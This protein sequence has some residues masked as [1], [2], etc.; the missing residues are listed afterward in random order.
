MLSRGGFPSILSPAM[1]KLSFKKKIKKALIIFRGKNSLSFCEKARGWLHERGVKSLCF[2]QEALQ[3]KTFNQKADLVLV[4]G[5]DGTYLN[6]VRF[7]QEKDIPFLGVNMGSL[8]FLTVHL[9]EKL[10]DCLEK[11]LKGRMVLEERPLIDVL[12]QKK[13]KKISCGEALNDVVMER[14]GIS[15]LIDIDV[16]LKKKNIYSLRADGLIVSSATGSTAYNLAA[17][18]PILHPSLLAFVVTPICSHSLTHRPVLFPDSRTLSFQIKSTVKKSAVLT[19][20]GKKRLLLPPLSWVFVK[21]SK[22]NHKALRDPEHSSFLFLKDKL[23]FFQ[24]PV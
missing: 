2:S 18:G 15:Q 6:A 17:G 10:F 21:K 8:G 14:G 16:Y 20:D 13:N 1:E 5:G 19:V 9:K 4:L 23:N 12:I 22:K 24:K 11:T 7:V 3:N